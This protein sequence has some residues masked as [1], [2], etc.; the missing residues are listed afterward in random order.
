MNISA[1]YNDDV[2]DNGTAAAVSTESAVIYDFRS[3][4]SLDGMGMQGA[5][6]F[7]NVDNLFDKQ[8]IASAH[9]YGV[10]PNKPQ[11]FIA[12]ISFDF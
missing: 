3:G 4:M 9:N 1:K 12:G 7:L 2:K 10:R 5:R 11:T 8:Y 6:A